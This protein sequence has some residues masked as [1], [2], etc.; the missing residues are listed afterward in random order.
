MPVDS[1]PLINEVGERLFSGPMGACTGDTYRWVDLLVNANA[2]DEQTGKD[3]ERLAGT[4]FLLRFSGIGELV[5]PN[6]W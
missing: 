4:M 6:W 3:P 1:H 5:D 2:S